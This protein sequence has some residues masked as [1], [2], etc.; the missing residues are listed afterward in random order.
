[1]WQG[2]ESRKKGCK[3]EG[4]KRKRVRR[5]ATSGVEGGGGRRARRYEY[6]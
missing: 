4:G 6:V 5:E 1:V 3:G 2:E